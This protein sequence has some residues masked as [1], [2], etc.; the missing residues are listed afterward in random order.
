M[1]FA[2][3]A[4]LW[5]LF[6]LLVPIAVHLFSFR[7]SKR[8][9]FSNLSLLT[10]I[11]Q[12]SSKRRLL[13][14][15]LLL[16]SRLLAILCLVLAFAQPRWGDA[17]QTLPPGSR[18]HALFVDN[19]PSMLLEGS[20]GLLLEQ[21]REA[22][23][24][25]ALAASPNERFQL[26]T[27]DF[28]PQSQR[29]LSRDAFLIALDEV[30]PSF[31][32]RLPQE[33]IDRQ[34][35]ALHGMEDKRGVRFYWISDFQKSAMPLQ[36]LKVEAGIDV[37][38]VQL[39]AE[40]TGNVYVD[41]AWLESPLLRKGEK[42]RLLFRLQNG[43][44]TDAN[45]VLVQLRI[46]DVQKGLANVDLAAGASVVDT[47]DFT[48][49]QTGVLA[50]SLELDDRVF[51][52]DDRW[53]M[54]FKVEEQLPLVYLH[55]E[56]ASPYIRAL[57]S[58]DDFVR[59]Q[60]MPALRVDLTALKAARAVVLEGVDASASGL[61]ASIKEQVEAGAS[62]VYLPGES[63]TKANFQQVLSYFT[64]GQLGEL[65]QEALAVRKLDLNDK[66]FQ[67]TFSRLPE[68][69]LLPTAKKYFAYKP[70]PADRVLMELA[71]GAPWFIRRELGNGNVVV[72]L[73]A[74]QPG[75]TD[76]PQQ[77]LFVP[78]FDRAVQL[79]GGLLP[80][81]IRLRNALQF[82][83]RSGDV[84]Q[85]GVLSLRNNQN[86]WLPE[87]RRI[88]NRVLLSLVG[89]NLGPGHYQLQSKE[90]IVS[91][92]LLAFNGDATESQL[93]Y[94]TSEELAAQLEQLGWKQQ[95]LSKA[96]L[97]GKILEEAASST[98]WKWLLLAVLVFLFI[99]ILILKFLR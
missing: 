48:P 68:Q 58:K 73:S 18:Y 14:E 4:A 9:L 87:V 81:S 96:S 37:Q 88:G 84:P 54:Q 36:A 92:V 89:S 78:T 34:I 67:E 5:G 22:A 64:G 97:A 26:L 75:W 76:M 1:N 82:E 57:F 41:T 99:E 35:D 46:S 33:I 30:R 25:I 20:E 86:S 62:L 56:K 11:K 53:F 61:L 21:A 8:V 23:R 38:C 98:A 19:S 49:D 40:E 31:V 85:E 74:L 17:A 29:W 91:N 13:K 90:Q 15:R 72:L 45:G 60:E 69:M 94:Y 93:Q 51:P 71:N 3:P 80:T 39:L 95:Q 52:Y 77:A 16:L 79:S 65:V 2:N 24:A 50:A 6:A 83:L 43:G 7:T 32:S 42:A 66:L 59:M 27:H 47:I 55:P 10:E 70:H 28:S 63:E 12:E 44:R